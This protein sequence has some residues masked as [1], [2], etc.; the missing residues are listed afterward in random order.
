MIKFGPSGNSKSFYDEGHKHTSE[1]P[2]WLKNLGLD[3]FEY[4]LGRGITIKRETA[5]AIAENAAA[6]GVELSVHAPYFIN[7]ANPASYQKSLEYILSSVEILRAF[8]GRRLVFHIGSQQKMTRAE[9]FQNS[10]NALKAVENDV[11]EIYPDF[12]ELT[13]CPETMGKMGQIG[14]V[15]EIIEVC[16]A[17][18]SFT[19]CVDFGHVNSREGGSLRDEAAF[20]GLISRFLDALGQRAVN[21]HVHFSRIEYSAGGEVR[22]LTFADDKYGP[23]FEHLAPVIIKRGLAPYIVC[24]SDGTQAEDALC[25]KRCFESLSKK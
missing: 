20:D 6:C 18:K 25:M 21:M 15:D 13:L 23:Y 22:H 17:I 16:R 24:E 11:R 2:E 19:P 12:S 3:C 10:L 14:S 8:G 1:T 4:S 9:A 7:F 5:V